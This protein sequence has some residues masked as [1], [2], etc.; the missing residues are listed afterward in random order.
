MKSKLQT[1]IKKTNQ[2]NWKDLYQFY[3]QISSYQD[4]SNISKYC[5]KHDL[6]FRKLDN[7]IKFF[8][9]LSS[10]SDIKTATTKVIYETGSLRDP[11]GKEGLHHLYEHLSLSMDLEKFAS[12][13][14]QNINAYTSLS[15]LCTLN[16]TGIW[17]SEYPTFGHLE[18]FKYFVKNIF[19]DNH[20]DEK[21]FAEQIAVINGEI[22]ES[23]VNVSRIL[24]RHLNKEIFGKDSNR[25]LEVLGTRKSLLA[26]SYDDVKNFTKSY[27]GTTNMVVLLYVTGSDA[28]F[29]K[30]SKEYLKELSK[31]P[32][33]SQGDYTKD[34]VLDSVKSL[35]NLSRR[36]SVEVPSFK[37]GLTDVN[38]LYPMNITAFTKEAIAFGIVAKVISNVF[39]A[40][41]R[42]YGLKSYSQSAN[43]SLFDYKYRTLWLS[44]TIEDEDL[45]LAEETL[46]KTLDDI[47]LDQL[48][49]E[50][51][52]NLQYT[53][54]LAFPISKFDNLYDLYYDISV[55][56]DIYM[57]IEKYKDFRRH[58][59]YADFENVISMIKKTNPYS[60]HI[61][62][63][64]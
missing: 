34:L 2:Q 20:I 23:E 50:Q 26:I 31:I 11:I 1:T 37:K 57:D 41:F 42:K 48:Y 32:K 15:E 62:Q 27:L 39:F 9:T 53:N 61:H 21:F 8:A 30:I 33:V 10:S 38:L 47:L 64:M 58:L 17:N 22:S 54:E 36:K 63:K 6:Y 24:A 51:A 7:G 46:M 13:H 49:I 16:M 3:K 12:G 18:T 25:C 35:K 52:I 44:C 43:S 29:D 14:A 59:K 56:G 60:I 28:D 19:D 45:S 40:K 55:F 4:I 5:E